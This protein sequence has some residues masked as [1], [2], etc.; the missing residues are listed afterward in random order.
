[1]F[2]E[3]KLGLA[4][5]L[6]RIAYVCSAQYKLNPLAIAAI[7]QAR[8]VIQAMTKEEYDAVVKRIGE[9]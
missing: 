3:T 8:A 9:D 4:H 5:Y 6:E 1:M 2:K 7:K